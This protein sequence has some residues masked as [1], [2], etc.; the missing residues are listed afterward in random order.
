MSPRLAVLAM[1]GA[2]TIY[3]A[4]F[5]VT[6]SATLAG[7]SAQD[8]A[9]LRFGTAGLILLPFFVGRGVRDCAGIGWFRGAMLCLTS[10]F[11]LA[12]LM[13]AGIALA[14]ASHGAAITPG[15][16][17]VVGVLLGAWL[18]RARPSG[19]TLVGIG[20]VLAGLACIGVAGSRHVSATTS[21]GDGLFVVSGLIWGIYPFLLQRWSV[22][23]TTS[24]AVVAVLSLA[25][26]PL[27]AVFAQS[28]L[29]ALPLGFVAFHAFNQG[30]LNIIVG[31]W[32]WGSAVAVLGAPLAQRFPP[33]IPVVGTLVAIP[34]VGEWPAPL[35]AAGVAVIV[36]G[37]LITVLGG[38][39]ARP[40][41]TS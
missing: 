27:Y 40:E 14:P 37:L 7:L 16:V 28:H 25:Y 20:L 11:P 39:R 1:L 32:L 31:L 8:L 41:T 17:T 13:N 26:L 18:N 29:G 33:L 21:L 2:V 3:G 30:V 9:A 15:T 12:L 36:A 35:Q 5:A 23:P 6:R 10:G 38:R 34:V 19:Q 22:P 24:T 4:N